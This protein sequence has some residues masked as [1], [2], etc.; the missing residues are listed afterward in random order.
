MLAQIH[1]EWLERK[2]LDMEE[3]NERKP[4]QDKG[5]VILRV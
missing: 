1:E 3:L 2:Y 5:P 4:P